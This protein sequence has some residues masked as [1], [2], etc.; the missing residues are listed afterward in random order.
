[1]LDLKDRNGQTWNDEHRCW[2]DI[3]ITIPCGSSATYDGD[4]SYICDHCGAVAGS[5]GRPRKCI[6]IDKKNHMWK[7][8]SDR[9]KRT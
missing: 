8:L 4:F 6:E 2:V 1:M 5:V 7:V 3:N 9:P